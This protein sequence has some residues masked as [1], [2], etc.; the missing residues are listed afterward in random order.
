MALESERGSFCANGKRKGENGICARRTDTEST[1]HLS[2]LKEMRAMNINAV[3]VLIIHIHFTRY[4][5]IL[6]NWLII[7]IAT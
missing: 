3:F 7:F 1:L 2:T 5:F 4:K 6:F